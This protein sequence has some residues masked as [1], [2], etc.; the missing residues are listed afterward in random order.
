MTRPTTPFGTDDSHVRLDAVGAA[1][2]DRDGQQTRVRV[3]GDHFGRQR[4]QLCDVAQLE[5]RFQL[6]G[7]GRERPLLLQ[8][9]LEIGDLLLQLLVL[10]LRVRATRRSWCR[11]R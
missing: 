11:C 1:A 3:A 6:G 5:Q 7:A 2:V 4:R 10:D 8:P 9:H